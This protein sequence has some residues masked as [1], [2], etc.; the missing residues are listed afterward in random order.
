MNLRKMNFLKK[1]MNFI[2]MGLGFVV[3]FSL[4]LGR[5]IRGFGGFWLW[6]WAFPFGVF[7]ELWRDAASGCELGPEVSQ[8]ADLSFLPLGDREGRPRGA[9]GGCVLGPG[10]RYA[11]TQHYDRTCLPSPLLPAAARQCRDRLLPLSLQKERFPSFPA[12][13]GWEG[14]TALPEPTAPPASDHNHTQREKQ[15][16]AGWKLL[17]LSCCL[18]CPDI[19]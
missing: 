14:I 2:V 11:A 19:V 3:N 6:G 18:C 4:G 8:G 1:F 17:L 10:L 7:Q 9:A 13:A 16:S 5:E 15:H 12:G